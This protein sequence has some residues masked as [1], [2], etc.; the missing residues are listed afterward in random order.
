MKALLTFLEAL[1]RNNDR[2]WFAEHKAEYD[3]LR[4][5]FEGFVSDLIAAIARFDP[6]V[7]GLAPKD[8]MYR[9]YR[10]TRFSNDKSPYKTHIGAFVCRGGKKSGYAGYYLH[11]E[12]AGEGSPGS[13]LSTGLYHPEPAVLRSIRDEIVT[14]GEA[15]ETLLAA[16]PEYKLS[17]EGSLRRVPAGYAADSPW[18]EYLKLKDFYLDRPLPSAMLDETFTPEL[19]ARIAR[20]FRPTAGFASLLNRCVDYARDELA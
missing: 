3:A 17:S 13:F 2:V 8:C 5:E 19:A 10:D 9:I 7:A 15:F 6:A 11:L 12:P 16:A 1:R 20:A 18:A 14:E 4:T